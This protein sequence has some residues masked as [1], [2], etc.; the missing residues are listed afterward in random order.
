MAKQ[1]NTDHNNPLGFRA[2]IGGLI[3]TVLGG[4]ILYAIT[5]SGFLE[6]IK[7]S[8]QSQPQANFVSS[9][10][11]TLASTPIETPMPKNVAFGKSG[12]ASKSWSNHLPNFAID[13]NYDTG[14][15]TGDYGSGWLEID[16]QGIFMISTLELVVAQNPDGETIHDLL[17]D[18]GS[19][20]FQKIHT[21]KSFTSD[22]Q[23]LTYRLDPPQ[24]VSKVKVITVSS[25]S[26]V[27]WIEVRAIG[28][29]K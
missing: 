19:G 3:V 11:T 16:L 2:V 12:T 27:A 15:N 28:Y 25:P 5:S 14:W 4:L 21:F 13:E 1:S 29:S 22:K 20:V 26:W 7:S 8:S 10:R 23:K 9:P 6:S 18:D 24:A 17:I